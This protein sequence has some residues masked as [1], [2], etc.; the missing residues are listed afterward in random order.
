MSK[1]SDRFQV[2][3]LDDYENVASGVPAYEQLKAR[4]DVTIMREQLATDAQ[5]ERALGDAEAVLLMRERTRLGEKQIRLAPALK[6]IS[7]TGNTSGHLDLPALTRRGIAV[8]ATPSDS[9]VSTI[10]LTIGLILAV[11]RRIPQVNG[12][13]RQEQWPALPGRIL[14]GKTV[15]VVGFGRIGREV[16]RIAKAFNTRV[17]ATARTLTEENARKVGAEKVSLERLLRESDIVTIHARLGQETR[18]LIGEK[19]FSLMKPDAVLINTAR[20]PIV[21]EAALIRALESKHLGGVG[22]DVFDEEPV[23]LDHPLRRFDN[24]VLLSHRGYAV[25][26][27]LRERYEAA[28]DN[29]IKFFDGEPVTLLNPEVLSAAKPGTHPKGTST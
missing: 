15:G 4:A 7:Q 16:A 21:S 8:S 28:M 22:L 19:E 1:S 5:L 17:L 27:I 20:G 10:E 26:E 12:R 2:V 11:M 14:E 23:P 18:G 3:V 25:V 13:M 9:G 6:L 24:A 29:I